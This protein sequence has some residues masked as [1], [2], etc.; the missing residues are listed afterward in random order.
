[1]RRGRT[2]RR[3]VRRVRPDG[4]TRA[5]DELLV[6][7]PMEIRL[8]DNPVTTTMR[9]P[10]HDF[11]L[12]AGFCH[13]E[14]LL[15]G[16]AIVRI[17]YCGAGAAVDSEFNVV[18]VE[19]GGWAPE[20]IPRLGTTSSS[21]G[22]CGT[23]AIERLTERLDPL[24]PVAPS[25]ATVL[26]IAAEVRAAQELFGLTG[27]SHGA[28][29]FDVRSGALGVVREDIGR[30]NAVDKVIGRLLLDG[31]L[32]AMTAGPAS[33]GLWISGRASLEMVVKAWAGGFAA[34]VSVSAPSSLAVEVAETAGLALF[35]FTRGDTTTIYHD[36]LAP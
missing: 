24:Q 25:A 36:P 11:E 26:G 23:T 14:G 10:G 27:S 35:G 5:P 19:T 1:M 15:A 31:D 12:A 18:S 4:A 16:A 21:C 2:Q 9:T 28:A 3:M 13:S 32:P 34:L 22:L 6:E 8:D 30:H 20:P 29:S 17:R 33:R 7:E